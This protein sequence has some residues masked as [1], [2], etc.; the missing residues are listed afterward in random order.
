MSKQLRLGR[1]FEKHAKTTHREKILDEMDRIVSWSELCGLAGCT[2][3]SWAG[4]RRPPK[5][6][7]VM[8]R[9]YVLQQ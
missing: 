7:E 2:E 4:D 1:G 5:D 8:L 3:V 9:I 6:L